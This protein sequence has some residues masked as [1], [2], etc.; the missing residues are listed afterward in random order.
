MNYKTKIRYLNAFILKLNFQ[1]ISKAV[2]YLPSA[3]K[4]CLNHLITFN[5]LTVLFLL[6]SRYFH[7]KLHFWNFKTSP[8]E[9]KVWLSLLASQVAL[10]SGFCSMKLLGILLLPPGWDASPSQGYLPSL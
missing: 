2:R 8:V 10:N 6:G 5:G 4:V 3:R 7:D 1:T 9:K